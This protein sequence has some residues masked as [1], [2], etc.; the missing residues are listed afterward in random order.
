[1]STLLEDLYSRNFRP[2]TILDVGANAGGWSTKAKKV[3][4]EADCYLIEPLLEMEEQLKKF[5]FKN[6]GSKY[7]LYGAGSKNETLYL[8]LGGE[9]LAGSNLSF[10]ESEALK[11]QNKQRQIQVIT[12]D[13]LIES[14]ELPFPDFVKVDVQGFELEALKG[15]QKL[16]EKAEVFILETN[17][18]EFMKGMPLVHE[19]ILYMS[20]RGFVVYDFP[21]FLRRPYDGALAQMDVCFVKRNGILR[22]SNLWFKQN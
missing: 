12:L 8:T 14:N 6:P 2:K 22:S 18:F 13:S 7:F 20:E 1:M 19:V 4:P 16:F 10:G 5:C 17:F 15:G 9:N 21:G 3:F 11:N